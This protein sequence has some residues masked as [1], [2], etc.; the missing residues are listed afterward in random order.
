MRSS[1]HPRLINGP[2][3][4][5]VLFIPFLFQKRALLFDLGD[6]SNL[7][8]KDLLK[9]THAFVTH[10]HMDHFIGFDNLLRLFLGRNKTLHLYGPPFFFHQVEGK[11]DGYTW[12]LVSENKSDFQLEV[13]EVHTHRIYTKTYVCQDRFRPKKEISSREFDGTLLKEPSFSV[14]GTLL[15]HRTPCLGLCLAERF[16][17]NI[18]KDGLK[19]LGIPA[20]PWL[21]RFKTAIYQGWDLR[22]EFKVTWE[23]EG[24]VT[25]EMQFPLGDLAEKIARVSPGQRISYITDVVA[26]PENCK[27]I[28]RLAR[29]VDLLFIEAA[30][31]SDQAQLARKK[32]HLTAWEAGHLAKKAGARQF[33]VFH[34]SPRYQGNAEK[35]TMEAKE[36]FEKSYPPCC[37]S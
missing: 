13:S 12:N 31:L 36:A 25:R 3:S 33:Q 2:F 9:V 6:L 26:S 7:S 37:M 1:F 17:V 28:I 35:I 18:I 27:K 20:G 4:D 32:Y 29:G 30:F 19:D 14:H 11:L 21:N 16:S 23:E 34:F 5:P 22:K 10:T 8:A 15:D 24:K